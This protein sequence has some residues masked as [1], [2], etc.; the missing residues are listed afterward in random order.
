MLSIFERELVGQHSVAV[1]VAVAVAETTVN[2]TG[3][4]VISII[5]TLQKN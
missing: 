3:S 5:L 4:V 2:D 1:A